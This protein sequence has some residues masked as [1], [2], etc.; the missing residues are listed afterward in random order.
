MQIWT[1]KCEPVIKELSFSVMYIFFQHIPHR[2]FLDSVHLLLFLSPPRTHCDPHL[3]H[4]VTP[5]TRPAAAAD[6]SEGPYQSLLAGSQRRHGQVVAALVEGVDVDA[7]VGVRLLEP[8]LQ[9]VLEVDAL[10]VAHPGVE[11]DLQRADADV[12]AALLGDRFETQ[13]LQVDGGGLLQRAQVDPQLGLQHLGEHQLGAELEEATAGLAVD[14]HQGL[15]WREEEKRRRRS[16]C[17][18]QLLSSRVAW[19]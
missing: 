6:R 18:Q 15:R 14:L 10:P 11:L 2:Y 4:H 16:Y 7:P 12:A 5:P 17:A 3:T 8:V 13:D 1:L 19:Q 9:H